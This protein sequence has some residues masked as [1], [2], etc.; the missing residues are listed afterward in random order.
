QLVELA[1][2]DRILDSS[3]ETAYRDLTLRK[4]VNRQL[5]RR[6]REIRIDTAKFSDELSNI[7]KFFGDWYLASIY[8]KI[9][10]RFHLKDWH[11]I[12]KEKLKTLGD[13]YQLLQ[14]DWVNFSMIILETA[15]VLLFIVDVILLLVAAH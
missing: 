15:I 3:L 14:Q 4:R 6:I 10:A 1:A 5:Q 7:T 13:L 2:Y 12:I 9:S 8:S 11:T